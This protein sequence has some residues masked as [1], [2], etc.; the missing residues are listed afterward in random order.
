[1]VQECCH[2]LW[3]FPASSRRAS[4]SCRQCGADQSSPE[5]FLRVGPS[6]DAGDGAFALVQCNG[7]TE[8][9]DEHQE[10]FPED[11]EQCVD[12]FDGFHVSVL[13]AVAEPDWLDA[14]TLAI[15]SGCDVFVLA[16]S[17]GHASTST[18]AHYVA[19]NPKDSSSLRLG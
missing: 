13:I 5:A 9:Q 7:D 3:A 4:S 18:T 10:R 12:V 6:R 8:E 14:I 1:M 17:L 15:R 2:H 11:L 16:G 19:A